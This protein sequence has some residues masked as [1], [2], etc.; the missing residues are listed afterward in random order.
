MAEQHDQPSPQ[1]GTGGPP[2]SGRPR[3]PEP[4]DR[5]PWA[6]PAQRVPLDKP[7]PPPSVADQPTVTS[8]PGLPPLPPQQQ[9]PGAP[10]SATP[11]GAVPPPPPAPT[12]PGTP[13]A[14]PGGPYGAA[15][16]GAQ[17]TPYA[18]A[19]SYGQPAPYGVPGYGHPGMG[20]PGPAGPYPPGAGYLP[21]NGNGTAALVLGIIGAALFFSIV[22]SVILGVLAIVFGALGRTKAATGEAT[23]GGMALAGLI[24]GVIAVV[25]SVVM[26]FVYI[27]ADED[28]DDPYDPYDD[29]AAVLVL[30]SAGSPLSV[31]GMSR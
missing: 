17:A 12:G 28:D 16:Y 29:T 6:P 23:N 22:L 1:D 27:A 10:P 21:N 3:Q 9:P 5:D 30:P 25:A 15:G 18:G 2:E 14:Y 31:A 13:S 26:V 20:H 4:R 8:A 11:P 19:P 7:V 24:L